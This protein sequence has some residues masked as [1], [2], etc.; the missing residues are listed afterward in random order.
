MMMQESYFISTAA[1]E[2]WVNPTSMFDFRGL[3]AEVIFYREA[4]E[5]LGVDVQVIRH[6]KFKGAVEPYM[7]DK[8]S[9]ENRYQ[10][11]EYIGSI[12]EP[13]G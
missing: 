5:K 9:D 8:L 11:S 13:C 2:I 10:I 4:L 3:A 1:D 12:W 6:G 7:L